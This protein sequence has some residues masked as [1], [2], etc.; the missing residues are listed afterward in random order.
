M[1]S[2]ERSET[3]MPIVNARFNVYVEEI[4]KNDELEING[5]RVIN[6][7]RVMPMTSLSDAKDVRHD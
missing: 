4:I 2:I 3:E 6:N 1:L 5:G 7:I